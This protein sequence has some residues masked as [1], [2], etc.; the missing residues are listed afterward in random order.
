MVYCTKQATTCM[1]AENHIIADV[2]PLLPHRRSVAVPKFLAWTMQVR[3][4]PPS[5][6]ISAKSK[7]RATGSITIMN[8]Q[9]MFSFLTSFALLHRSGSCKG[10]SK[11]KG[12]QKERAKK[13]EE[14]S[15]GYCSG[16][17]SEQWFSS[18]QV[19]TLTHQLSMTGGQDKS[20]KSTQMCL[21]LLKI[22]LAG[23]RAFNQQSSKHEF[24]GNVCAQ[25]LASTMSG[26]AA[27]VY[28][29]CHAQ[30]G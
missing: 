21:W 19:S 17:Q 5:T 8:L 23:T 22:S 27:H 13:S 14:G 15:G 10:C 30:V 16:Q 24:F 28:S 7:C 9:S 12:S 2:Y 4:T 18:C 20:C 29:V 3:L 6:L 25:P 11:I 1:A 26:F